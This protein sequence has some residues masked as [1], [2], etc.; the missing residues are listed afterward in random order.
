[1]QLNSRRRTYSN[2]IFIQCDG[3]RSNKQTCPERK[4][5]MDTNTAVVPASVD[6]SHQIQRQDSCVTDGSGNQNHSSTSAETDVITA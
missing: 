1:M 6:A 2:R 5:K 4:L 3:S